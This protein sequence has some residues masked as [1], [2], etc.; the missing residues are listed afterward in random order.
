MRTL[1]VEKL[2]GIYVLCSDAEK[3]MYAIEQAEAPAGL[4]SG[5]I[6]RI[7]DEGRIAVEKKAKKK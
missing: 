7:D 3:K 6:L 1:K 5:D 4:K 2:E